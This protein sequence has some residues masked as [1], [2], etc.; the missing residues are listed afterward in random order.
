MKLWFRAFDAILIKACW[1][2]FGLRKL[3]MFDNMSK[4]RVLTSKVFLD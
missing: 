2:A 3:V 4:G 1:S